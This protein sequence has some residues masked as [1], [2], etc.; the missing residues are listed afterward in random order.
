M[1]AVGTT[2]LTSAGVS[3][4]MVVMAALNTGIKFQF[5]RQ[6]CLHR[7]ICIT[8]YTSA[9]LNAGLRQCRLCTAS[10]TAADQ[11]IHTVNLQKSGQR[12]P[13]HTA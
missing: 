11:Q 1:A 8:R 7:R 2:P 4:L 13:L 5:S 10:N 12:S 6:Q 9:Q 3:V